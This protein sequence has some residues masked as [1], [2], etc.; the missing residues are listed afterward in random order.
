MKYYPIN[1]NT[2]YS[3]L[4][5]VF[6]TNLPNI[7]ALNNLSNVPNIGEVYYRM[8]DDIIEKNSFKMERQWRQVSNCLGNLTGDDDVYE[9][10]ATLSDEDWAL[11]LSINAFYGYL[12]IPDDIS[13]PLTNGV[14]G[15]GVP[16]SSKIVAEVT[17]S[18]KTY[19]TIPMEIFNG[20]VSTITPIQGNTASGY[21]DYSVS[22][23]P[24]N[25][26]PIPW[27][28]IML[29]S[30]LFDDYVAIPVYPNELSDGVKANFTT[31]P[32]LLY[33]YEPWQIYTSSGPRENTYTFDFHR[34]MWTG[35]HMDGEANNM[36][37]FCEACC[38][39]KF[40]GSQVD[41]SLVIL[42][43]GGQPLIRGILTQVETK[44][45]GPLGQDEFYLHC[46]MTL[47]IVEVS[48]E[49]LSI[50]VVRNKPLIG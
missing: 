14:L 22:D 6:G 17:N 37:R 36:I 43:I 4:Y 18:L 15:S 27:G 3:D 31:M 25:W 34:D 35:N 41:Y 49:P 20:E 40:T 26:F 2:T 50:E 13:L 10:A 48:S 44:W 32:E 5:S 47:H 8:C 33:Q 9:K 39:P 42:Y 12:K 7:L 11:M 28:K 38:Y 29:Y 16:V 30:E 1:R 21:R 23:N 45:D 19:H 24:M 46:V